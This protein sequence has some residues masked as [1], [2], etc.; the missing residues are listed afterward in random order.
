MVTVN[1]VMD[2]KLEYSDEER[3]EISKELASK[4][5][6][7]NKLKLELK[8]ATSEIK[9]NIKFIE[10]E[11]EGDIQTLKDGFKIVKA[12]NVQC[13]LN[14]DTKQ[15][16]TMYGDIVVSVEPFNKKKHSGFFGEI[17]A[18]GFEDVF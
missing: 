15:V 14:E 11:L 2:V 9:S 10:N 12:A 8:Q 7:I 18:S 4:K 17:V 16:T 6:K 3:L 1:G 5:D 13:E